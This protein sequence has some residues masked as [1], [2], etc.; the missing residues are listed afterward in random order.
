MNINIVI[1]QLFYDLIGRI[2]PG[3]GLSGLALFLQ[4]G[5]DTAVRIVTTWSMERVWAPHL[6]APVTFVLLGNLLVSYL[7]GS[8]L[9]SIW[10]WIYR[11]QWSDR[12]EK[13]LDEHLPTKSQA[14]TIEPLECYGDFDQTLVGMLTRLRKSPHITN[15]IGL[16]YDFVQFK[17]PAAAARIAKLRA[18]QH[19][20]GVLFAGFPVI[21]VLVTIQLVRG[22]SPGFTLVESALIICGLLVL[23]L[24]AYRLARHLDERI[25]AALFFNWYIL[26]CPN[27]QASNLEEDPGS[28]KPANPGQLPSDRI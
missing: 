22:Y 23:T 8:L 16:L 27:Y 28:R 5:P 4:Y 13:F 9:G 3:A 20:S 12:C 17:N 19:M 11:W 21:L 10:F 1:P 18:E 2:I 24:I 26:S 7:V 14:G 15:R 25:T 6:G